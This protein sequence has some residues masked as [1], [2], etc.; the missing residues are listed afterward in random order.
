MILRSKQFHSLFVFALISVLFYLQ[1]RRLIYLDVFQRLFKNAYCVD[2]AFKLLVILF[3]LIHRP[4]LQMVRVVI[5]DR[6]LITWISRKIWIVENDFTLLKDVHFLAFN[7]RLLW[8]IGLSVNRQ[9]RRLCVTILIHN[10]LYVFVKIVENVCLNFNN[11][12]ETINYCHVQ[13][14]FKLRNSMSINW[15]VLFLSRNLKVIFWAN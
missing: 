4:L 7:L 5:V 2:C 11:L 12:T 15:Y 1:W 14:K 6:R 13:F 10:Y 3:N 9:H 8:L